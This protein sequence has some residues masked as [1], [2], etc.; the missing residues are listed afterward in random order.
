MRINPTG[1]GGSSNG[2]E[3]TAESAAKKAERSPDPAAVQQAAA[4]ETAS[5]ILDRIA[6]Q[7]FGGLPPA[8]QA[9]LKQ[10]LSTDPLVRELI[11]GSTE[12]N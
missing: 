3:P 10:W 8:D 2:P 1:V 6:L 11:A 7:E 9:S 4:R 12:R 5:Q